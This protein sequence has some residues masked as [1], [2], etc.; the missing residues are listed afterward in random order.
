MA[1][2]SRLWAKYP[3]NRSGNRVRT[4]NRIAAAGMLRLRGGGG[5]RGGLR[6]GR[7]GFQLL[8]LL[9]VLLQD[10]RDVLGRLRPDALPVL[11]PGRDQLHPLVLVLDVRVVA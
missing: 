3:W 8:E 4:S 6:G 9:H 5:R 11:D 2:L 1:S 7:L 10:R